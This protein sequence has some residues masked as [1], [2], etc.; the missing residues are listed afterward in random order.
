MIHILIL[1]LAL[2]VTG[3]S[4]WHPG[5]IVLLDYAMT[6]HPTPSWS[7]PIMMLGVNTLPYLFGYQIASK[8]LFVLILVLAGYL[9]VRMA[10]MVIDRF[11]VEEKWRVWME[12][13]GAVFFLVNPFAYERMMTQPGIY[14]GI[15]L[16]G[17]G[18][19]SLFRSP[20]KCGPKD[21]LL[22]GVFFGLAWSMFPHAI[23]MIALIYL[24][25][26]IAFVRDLQTGKYLM[27]SGGIMVL[28][29]LNW[30]LSPLFGASNSVTSIA[31]F[32][33]DNIQAFLSN[34]L[35]PFG[36]VATNL[37]LYGFWGERYHHF[38]LPGAVN[39]NWSGAALVLMG[40]VSIGAMLTIRETKTRRYGWAFLGIGIISLILGIGNASPLT[41]PIMDFLYS[42]VPYFRGFREPQKWIG[43]VLIVYGFFFLVSVSFVLQKWGKH[44]FFRIALV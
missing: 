20:E 24:A 3:S 13:L 30:L 25:W 12:G 41:A 19:V 2:L 35:P 23:F 11:G 1:S 16:I 27:Y 6:S 42:S 5:G 40:I 10:R 31:S 28:L 34:A 38:L 32:G 21:M 14:L 9:G 26:A 4:L 43:V 39:P 15:L 8:A 17:Y 37:S 36:P 29:N 18:L 22:S 44:L 33:N 7:H